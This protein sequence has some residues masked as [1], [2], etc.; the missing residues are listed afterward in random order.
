MKIV[1]KNKFIK[2]ILITLILI[3]FFLLI[4]INSCFSHSEVKYKKVSVSSGD[5]LWNIA[6]YEKSNNSYFEN[7]DIRYIVDKIK[8]INHL[9]NSNINVGDELSIPTI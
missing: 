8:Y 4:L 3:I 2:S 6:K 1:N 5:T 7:K 9:S